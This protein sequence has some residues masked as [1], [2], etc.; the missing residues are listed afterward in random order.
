MLRV[1]TAGNEADEVDERTSEAHLVNWLTH[2][3]QG[4]DPAA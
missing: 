3:S 4:F 2:P 1:Y